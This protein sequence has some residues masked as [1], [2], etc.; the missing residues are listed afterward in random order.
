MFITISCPAFIWSGLYIFLSCATVSFFTAVYHMYRE[1]DRFSGVLAIVSRDASLFTQPLNLLVR[2]L[3]LKCWC[4][5]MPFSLQCTVTGWAQCAKS[6]LAC[7]PTETVQQ[8]AES[9]W[10]TAHRHNSNITDQHCRWREAVAPSRNWPLYIH[11]SNK[12][13]CDAAGYLGQWMNFM[14]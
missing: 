2:W 10:L 3:L 12:N 11:S 13:S 14:C 8:T 9:Q 1:M 7:L 4:L 6:A 5:H